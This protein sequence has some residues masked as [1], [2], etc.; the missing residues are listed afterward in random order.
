[1]PLIYKATN[2]INLKC[3]IGKTIKTLAQRKGDHV[4]EAKH[5]KTNFVFHKALMKYGIDNFDWEIIKEC[6][7]VNE[8]DKSEIDLIDKYDS[9][10]GNGH[11]YNMIKDGSSGMRGKKWSAVM[12]EK[13]KGYKHSPEAIE[14]I[15]QA[16][17]RQYKDKPNFT[18]KDRTHTEETKRLMRESALERYRN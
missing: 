6:K 4:Y 16:S 7:S 9:F 11:G 5:K 1:M 14:K 17:I 15:R 13:R 8:M 3:Y 12:R 2:K 18:M 10:Y